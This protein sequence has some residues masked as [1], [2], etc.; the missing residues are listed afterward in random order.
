MLQIR[1]KNKKTNPINNLKNVVHQC[2]VKLDE[3]DW[4]P[5]SYGEILNIYKMQAS[6]LEK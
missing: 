5:H 2:C 6:N 4:H 1:I 3:N